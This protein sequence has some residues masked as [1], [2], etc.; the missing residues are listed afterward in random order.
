[1][2]VGTCRTAPWNSQMHSILKQQK[3]QG[4][5]LLEI[6]LGRRNGFAVAW[7][8]CYSSCSESGSYN[9]P[10]FNE[11]RE[12]SSRKLSE[13]K[14]QEIEEIGRGWGKLLARDRRSRNKKC[15]PQRTVRFEEMSR[16]V[17]S[18]SAKKCAANVDRIGILVLSAKTSD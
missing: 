1:M 6:A 18:G 10:K 11:G 9:C 2:Q 13:R 8:P 15:W 3:R 16:G 12:M 14:R 4:P 17:A 5:S 7:V